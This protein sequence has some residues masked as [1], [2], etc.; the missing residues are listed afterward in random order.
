MHEGAVERGWGEVEV[1]F[2][3]LGKLLFK[4]IY[5]SMENNVAW[6]FREVRPYPFHITISPDNE[7]CAG[8]LAIHEYMSSGIANDIYMPFD[9]AYNLNLRD[10]NGFC[11]NYGAVMPAYRD[12]ARK[13]AYM[14]WSSTLGPHG[15]IKR[16]AAYMHKLYLVR[17][18]GWQQ[19]FH[20][21]A[22]SRNAKKAWEYLLNMFEYQ[23]EL[24]GIPDNISD[25]NQLQWISTKPP[26]HGFAAV[27]ILDNYDV[28]AL[29][30]SDYDELY[31]KLS[32]FTD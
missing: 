4:K 6:Y 11:E 2:S 22:I 16:P 18:F 17:A 25:R 7:T 30:F 32:K 28:S 23:D 1:A 9:E 29:D 12:M 31:V 5:G 21:M 15:S 19:C 24:G 14:V 20:A 13:A 3:D 8:E 10:F 27:Y 26:I